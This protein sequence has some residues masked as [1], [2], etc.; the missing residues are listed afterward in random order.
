MGVY[1]I[2]R[3]GRL[4]QGKIGALIL[5]GRIK[6]PRVH[7]FLSVTRVQVS[8]D[9]SFADVYISN[10]REHES[11]GRA[12]AGLQNAAGFIQAELASFMQ[13]RKIPRLRFH[14]DSGIREGFDIVK[15]LEELTGDNDAGQ[16]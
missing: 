4:I 1:R 8:R 16:P 9:L 7:P 6:D 3:V 14:P 11:L 5:E 15:K 12:V 10:I 13:I 2:E